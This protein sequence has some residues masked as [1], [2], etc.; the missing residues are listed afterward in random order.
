LSAPKGR[1]GGVIASTY[2]ESVRG[3][4]EKSTIR[5]KACERIQPSVLG[6]TGREWRGIPQ[7]TFGS[8]A[9]IDAGEDTAETS[10]TAAKQARSEDRNSADAEA[11]TAPEPL[12]DRFL[13]DRVDHAHPQDAVDVLQEGKV[14]SLDQVLL[15][16]GPSQERDLLGVLDQARVRETVFAFEALLLGG[17]ASERW[18]RPLDCRAQ[19]VSSGL[20]CALVTG[21]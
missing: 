9:K 20:R 12:D 1:D 11:E 10:T 2:A 8:R 4:K 7:F 19:R 14:A 5:D 15:G 17:I 18:R 6:Q 21:E 13:D 16:L 3:R